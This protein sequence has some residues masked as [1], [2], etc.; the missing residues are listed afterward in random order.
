MDERAV[1]AE[2]LSVASKLMGLP[3][4]ALTY[5]T[6]GD[7]V[8]APVRDGSHVAWLRVYPAWP[9][10]HAR[11]RAGWETAKMPGVSKPKW[12]GCEHFEHD[13]RTMR[14][15]LLSLAPSPACTS[16]LIL[17][18]IP[19]V[20]DEWF[21][22]MRRSLDALA[23]WKTDRVCITNPMA[24]KATV[25]VTGHGDMHWCNL[26]APTF[27]LLDWDSWG[28]VPLGFDAATAYCS[29]LL[30]PEVADEVYATFRDQLETPDGRISLT[31]AANHLLDIIA[32][33]QD[34]IDHEG[35]YEEISGPLQ[36]LLN[37]L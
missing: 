8:G 4:G 32:A 1:L 21:A 15:D 7:S 28:K 9:A 11:E 13:G 22:D 19:D 6:F 37:S 16:E 33:N 30:V 35:R 34:I 17:T 5:A 29:A 14:A 10:E 2:A 3:H 18:A 20:T 36:E 24:T 12:Y 25:W 31:I 26:T 23:A 27:C